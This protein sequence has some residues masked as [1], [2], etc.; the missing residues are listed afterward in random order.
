MRHLLLLLSTLASITVFSQSV[1][2]VINLPTT[3]AS[4]P[5]RPSLIYYPDDYNST[6]T[7]YPLLVFLHGSGESGTNLAQI[8]NSTTA[9]GPAYLIEHGGWPSSFTNPGDGKAY[10]FIVVS[11]QSNNSWSSSGDETENM[12]KYLVANYRVD[13][14]RIYITGLSAGGGG[15][16][17]YAAHLNGDENSLTSTRTYLAAAIVPMSAATLTPIQSWADKIV[18]DN[19]RAWGLGDP[20]NDTYGENTMNLISYINK[21]KAG[22]GIFSPNNYGH[23]GW[24]NLYIPTFKQTIN[25]VSM[26]IYEWMLTNTRGTSTPVSGGGPTPVPAPTVSAGPNQT[27]TLPSNVTLPGVATAA[28]G[29]SIV[30]YSWQQVIGAAGPVIQSPTSATTVVSNLSPGVYVYQLTVKQDDG[31]TA[32]QSAYVTVNPALATAPTVSAGPNQTIALPSNV[33]L[34]GVATAASGHSIVAYSWQQVIGAAGPVI[35]SPTSATTVVSNL[36]PGVYVYQLTVKQDDGQTALQSAYVTVNPALA[37]LPVV[38]AGPN[39]TIVLPSNATLPGTA[40]AASGHSIVAYSWQQVMGAAGPVIQSPTSATTVVS[41]LSPGVYVYQ[42]TVKQD[43]G[44]TALQSAYVTVFSGTGTTVTVNTGSNQ[45][46]TLPANSATLN[47]SASTGTITSYAW[48]M[49]S[50]PNTPTIVSP[51]SAST[52]VSGLI[53]GTY[54]FKL[55]LNGGAATATTTIT[56]NPAAVA[57]SCKGG[58]YILAPDPVDSSVYITANNSS[59]KPGDTLILNKAYSSVDIQGLQGSASCPIVI[60]NQGVQALV[61]KRINLDGCTYVKLTGSGSSNQYGILI[62]QDPQLRQQSFTAIQVNDKSKNIEIERV[63]MHNVDIGIVAETN[64]DCDVSLDYPNWVL[65]SL[66]IHDNKIVGTWNEGMYIG[67]T[68]PDNASYDLRP[69]VCN[70]VTYYY[71]PMKNGYAHIYN[72]IVDSTGRGGIQLSNAASGISEINNNNISHNGLNGDDAQGSAITLGLYTRAYVHDNTIHNTYT[73]G[74]A[75]IGAGATNIPLR[76][77]NNTIDS[78]GYLVTYNL[79]TTSR[80]VYDPRNEPTFANTLTW[81]Q[82]I[83]IDTRPRLYTTDSPHPGTAVKGQDSTQFYIISNTI[84]LKKNSI[85][86]NV[87]DDYSGLQKNGNMICGNK[88]AGS[89]T[90]ATINVVSGIAYSSTCTGVTGTAVTTRASSAVVADSLFAETGKGNSFVLSPNP[91]REMVTVTINNSHTGVM[92][93]QLIDPSGV[94]RQNQQLQK[95]QSYSQV[96]LSMNGLP[97]GLYFVRVQVGNWIQTGKLLKL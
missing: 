50:G 48:T 66:N 31:Q 32:L 9:G 26:N 82:S 35:Q 45:T 75:S 65:D 4:S 47:G 11:P 73:W 85:A 68:S 39:Q 49:T 16:V 57:G 37:A 52:N 7:N 56:V 95:E 81:P 41:N 62:Q 5:T 72:N 54:Q 51:S 60:M 42:L 84:G 8:Y 33:T 28:S 3:S 17:E 74:I 14:N 1:E 53:A 2:K 34:P 6:S 44:Q 96:S 29:H 43:D 91:A 76:I 64:E 88:N 58:R 38:S 86:I 69:V 78:S 70:G 89:G 19:V 23:G 55:S 67:N 25:G 59:Y 92:N 10:K 24:A 21:D 97:A 12:V 40:T 61:T 22:Y 13:I 30:A 27:V 87:D 90:A 93:I 80:I 71:A 79:A 18:G 83:E 36:S 46:I 15:A 20:N 77:E 94:I 63:S